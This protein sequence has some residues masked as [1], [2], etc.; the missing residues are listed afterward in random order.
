MTI[1]DSST[2]LLK[3]MLNG[4]QNSWK[5]QIYTKAHSSFSTTNSLIFDIVRQ[6]IHRNKW[7]WPDVTLVIVILP[8]M[9]L[10]NEILSNTSRMDSVWL[11]LFTKNIFLMDCIDLWQNVY[12]VNPIYFQI[13][14]MTQFIFFQNFWQNIIYSVLSELMILSFICLYIMY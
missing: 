9:L 6:E 12:N 8:S 2:F 3:H 11:S 10:N 14:Q 5:Q 4:L 7:S 1:T 13:S